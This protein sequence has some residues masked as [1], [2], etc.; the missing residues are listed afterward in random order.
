MCFLSARAVDGGSTPFVRAKAVQALCCIAVPTE[1]LVGIREA[2]GLYDLVKP[3]AVL[4]FVLRWSSVDV[5]N[6]EKLWMILTTTR[7]L[8]AV[9]LEDLFLDP[10]AFA[11]LDRVLSSLATI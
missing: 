4:P 8:V 7:T 5:I 10:V 2:F 6:G 3:D 11:L 9:V 1:D